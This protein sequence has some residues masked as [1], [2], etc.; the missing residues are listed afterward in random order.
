[1]KKER[2]KK[3]S[4]LEFIWTKKRSKSFF[5]L[6]QVIVMIMAVVAIATAIWSMFTVVPSPGKYESVK[7]S[8]FEELERQMDLGTIEDIGDVERVR[9]GVAELKNSR[10]LE[11]AGIETLLA[12]LRVVLGQSAFGPESNDSREQAAEYINLVDRLI[13][14]VREKKPF[15]VL[16]EGSRSL[17]TDLRSSVELGQKDLAL[18]QLDRL[19]VSLGTTISVVS[20]EAETNRSWTVFS[21]LLGG[22]RGHSHNR[23]FYNI[24]AA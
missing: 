22:S 8:F 21:A 1:M 11:V 15:S 2:P 20:Q 24:R 19:A 16:P 17:A 9:L 4:E 23:N 3:L 7:S 10:Q 14:E 6:D 5:R 12:Q 13:D 18:N